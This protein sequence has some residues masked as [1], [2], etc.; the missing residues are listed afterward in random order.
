M[1]KATQLR[2]DATNR[3]WT[4]AVVTPPV[5]RLLA[6]ALLFVLACGR[7]EVTAGDSSLQPVPDVALPSLDGTS[8]SIADYPG[9]LVVVDFWATWCGP[10]VLQAEFME[11]LHQELEGS[12]VQFLA[13]N[14]GEPE[15]IVREY[16]R[17]RPFSY[18]VLLDTEEVLGDKL[19]IYALPTVMVVDQEGNISFLRPGIANGETLHRLLVEAGA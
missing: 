8:R 15:A 10:C 16:A 7:G 18:P 17:E 1:R 9:K 5:A 13:V 3:W 2:R 11:K 4:G 19:Q 14:L 6:V 12:N